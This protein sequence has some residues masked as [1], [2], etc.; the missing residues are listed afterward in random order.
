LSVPTYPL[1]TNQIELVELRLQRRPSLAFCPA[2][3]I[4]TTA[5]DVNVPFMQLERHGWDIHAV[6]P[7]APE[8]SEFWR[9]DE[10]W[11]RS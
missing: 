9:E 8:L 1:C 11:L 4:R 3:I 7:L 5:Y 10:E 2:G 6:N